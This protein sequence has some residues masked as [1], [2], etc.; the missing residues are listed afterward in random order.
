[1][2]GLPDPAQ[3]SHRMLIAVL[4]H[5]GGSLDLPAAALDRDATG[6]ADAHHAVQLAT[7]DDGTMRLS[8]VAR[9]P[10]DDAGIEVRDL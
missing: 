10:V 9:P 3:M 4:M 5:H 7:L 6:T 2:T 1:M 8:V